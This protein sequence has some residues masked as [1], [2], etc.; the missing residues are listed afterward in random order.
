MPNK[1]ITVRHKG[2]N[3]V[4]FPIF[5]VK[6]T[7]EPKDHKT[8]NYIEYFEFAIVFFLKDR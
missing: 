4:D 7:K 8:N 3:N 5:N 2:Y 1:I 6:I